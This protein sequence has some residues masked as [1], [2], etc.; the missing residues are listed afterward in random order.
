[1]KGKYGILP[2]LAMAL[3]LV[4]GSQTARAEEAP[5]SASTTEVAVPA[6]IVAP[7]D[8]GGAVTLNIDT[9]QL[10]DGGVI[11]I[12]GQ[13]PADKP[14][15][16]EI[17]NKEHKVRASRFDSDPIKADDK[18]VGVSSSD[19]YYMDKLGKKA[20][21][22]P[23]VFYITHEMPSYYMLMVTDNEANK[24]AFAEQKDKK[25]Q[26]SVS[27]LIK[28]LGA[29][30]AYVAPTQAKI[31]HFQSTLLASVI[32]SRG[33]ELEALDA[34]ETKARSMQ[35]LKARFR[36]IGK[37]F[38]VGVKVQ[39]DGHY[40]AT[41]KLPPKSAPGEYAIVASVDKNTKS[42]A[43]T[44]KND[45]AFPTMYLPSAGTSMNLIW[46]FVITL[47]VAIFGVMMGAGGG[48]IM[49]PLFAQIFPSLPHTYIAGTV[50]P[51]VLF[52]QGS[53]I[54]NYS[55][56]KFISWKLGIGIGLAMMVG[57]F[58]GP[59]LTEMITLTQF[60]F[61]FGWI[62]IVLAVLM[63]WQTTPGYLEKNKKEQAI[64]KEFKKRAEEAAKAKQA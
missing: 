3:M 43:V 55:K 10:H 12:T 21:D 30:D 45:I 2:W 57:G 5:P 1:M 27:A 22:R 25:G 13:A 46:P 53:G 28:A 51:T 31:D 20:G 50:T 33:E 52:S 11:T 42:E 37:V 34:K 17:Y 36:S 63:F 44:F 54:M 7:A 14:V 8:A 48:F 58:I 38:N 15:F 35:L 39:P 6:Q 56:I 47:L 24:A 32:G 16:V 4:L 61:A 40:E 62:L 18:G 19:K 49:N 9:S 60:K 23:Y 29:G 59:K 64:L 26:W 41:F